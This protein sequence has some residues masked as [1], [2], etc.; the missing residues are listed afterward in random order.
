MGCPQV[1][2]PSLAF[3]YP[4]PQPH[5]NRDSSHIFHSCLCQREPHLL[6]LPRPS[7][8]L[9]H[10]T[11]G[12]PVITTTQGF[13]TLWPSESNKWR[14]LS[15]KPWELE[16]PSLEMKIKSAL[17]CSHIKQCSW[18]WVLN[19]DISLCLTLCLTQSRPLTRREAKGE[20]DYYF[21][22]VGTLFGCEIQDMIVV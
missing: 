21:L 18:L 19:T 7:R 9:C 16:S 4:H 6:C 12:N 14:I 15:A 3:K 11:T 20:S 2:L 8:T 13:G 17:S 5:G 1:L 10:P 22:E